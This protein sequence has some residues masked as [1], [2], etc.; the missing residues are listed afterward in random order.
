MVLHGKVIACITCGDV[1]LVADTTF[2]WNSI[3]VLGSKVP[4]LVNA[5]F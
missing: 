4:G 1:F 3:F 5:H 2:M